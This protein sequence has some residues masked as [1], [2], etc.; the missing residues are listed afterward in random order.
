MPTSNTPPSNAREFA[1]QR[2]M[3]Y[4][5]R[6]TLHLGFF[7]WLP[8]MGLFFGPAALMHFVR[9]RHSAKK[10]WNPVEWQRRLGGIL[11]TTGILM[12]GILVL[13]A[14]GEG[15][16]RQ[17]GAVLVVISLAMMAT[18]Y[19]IGMWAMGRLVELDLFRERWQRIA[20][21]ALPMTIWTMLWI[22]MFLHESGLRV[23]T[24]LAYWILLGAPLLLL[25][26][27]LFFPSL[28]AFF[29]RTLWFPALC[30]VL[31]W[32][33]AAI[34]GTFNT[35]IDLVTASDFRTLGGASMFIIAAGAVVILFTAGLRRFVPSARAYYE[36]H[37][38]FA[39]IYT[40][41][42][43]LAATLVI[44]TLM[45]ADPPPDRWTF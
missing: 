44:L 14:L 17:N 5:S 35:W 15:V 23:L 40:I 32:A 18:V 34:G 24:S 41:A 4:S 9:A 2:D 36:T 13:L 7:S 3:I 12:T 28:N 33:F 25:C 39:V 31:A 22:L 1:L 11:A 27:S 21:A 20:S 19:G 8:L 30:V 26:T 38:E 37:P 16:N 42:F 29:H 10:V 6:R 43:W 45:F